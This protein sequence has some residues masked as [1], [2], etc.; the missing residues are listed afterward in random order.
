MDEITSDLDIF[1]REGILAFLRAESELRGATIFYCTHIFDHL[2]GWAS[3]LLHMSKGQVVKSC[4]IEEL[5]E[6]HE[7]IAQGNTTPLYSLIRKWIYSEYE[8]DNGARPW[9]QMED[10]SDGRRPNLGLAG[11]IVMRSG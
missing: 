4:V 8:A 9:R 10:T 6:Y 7:I 2:E 5:S 11:P 1:A 3:H